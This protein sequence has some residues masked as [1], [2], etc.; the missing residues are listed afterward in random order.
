[1]LGRCSGALRRL[2]IVRNKDPWPM[3]AEKWKSL[4]NT[5]KTELES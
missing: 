5:N 3:G 4:I 2:H 1:M